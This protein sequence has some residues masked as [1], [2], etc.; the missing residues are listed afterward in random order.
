M[1]D[2]P[3]LGLDCLQPDQELF[4]EVVGG[5]EVAIGESRKHIAGI[6]SLACVLAKV[7]RSFSAC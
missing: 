4:V 7:A 3:A 1:A 6:E 5:V 2:A